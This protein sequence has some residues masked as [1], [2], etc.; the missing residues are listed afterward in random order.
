[1]LTGQIRVGTIPQHG[2]ACVV[3]EEAKKFLGLDVDSVGAANAPGLRTGAPE[4]LSPSQGA[5]PAQC[6]E[7][8]QGGDRDDRKGNNLEP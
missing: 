5:E 1:M 8:D 3:A 4:S 7:A 2:K 6:C